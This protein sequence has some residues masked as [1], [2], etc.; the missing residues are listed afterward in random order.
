M[1]NW[2]DLVLIHGN[3]EGARTAFERACEMIIGWKRRP[4]TVRGIRV[5]QGDGGID[6]YVGDFGN[7][8]I[9]VYQCK[10]FIHG[11]DDSQKQQ[12]RNSYKTAV[13]SADFKVNKWYLCLPVNLSIPETTW[14]EGW[15]KSLNPSV[16]LLPPAELMIDAE[17]AGLATTIFQ[18]NDS[19][20][21]DRIV[22]DLKKHNRDPWF[23]L[24]AETEDDCF[25]ILLK[26]IREHQKCIGD[27]YPHLNAL[28]RGANAGDKLDACQYLKSVLVGAI[29][30]NHKVWLLNML[31]DFT[32]EPIAYRFIR[33]YD[34]LIEKASELGH[35][36]VLSTT[37]F[38]STW[39][40]LRSPAISS[41][42]DQAEW[43]VK[44]E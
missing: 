13:S 42:R 30:T 9:D 16:T 6:V 39:N 14:F 18:R 17:N 23:A 43:T 24:V 15:S 38:Y 12:I 26:L 8:P 3:I 27:Q 31:S 34:A 36:P 40:L 35:L 28:A 11:I 29:E 25:Q 1:S 4:E 21:L 5:Q 32:W 10:Y 20:K 2:T 19:L 41:L 44:F 7:T 33:R 22:E 37:E